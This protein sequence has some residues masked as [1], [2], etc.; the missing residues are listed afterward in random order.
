MRGWQYVPDSIVE[1]LASPCDQQFIQ[2]SDS[3][4]QKR[5]YKEVSQLIHD[6]RRAD[7]LGDH[8]SLPTVLCGGGCRNG[9]YEDYI[10]IDFSTFGY[11]LERV[12]ADVPSTLSMPDTDSTNFH[13]LSVAFG[14]SFDGLADFL[15]LTLLNPLIC[16]CDHPPNSS[17]KTGLVGLV[18]RFSLIAIG[19]L[20]E[21]A[22]IREAT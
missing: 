7:P 21:F 11:S 17:Q 8:H 2:S 10:R 13:R 22:A 3:E 19:P 12:A 16:S 1:Y 14:L 15:T 9:L 18:P 4:F 20:T 6:A 5:Y